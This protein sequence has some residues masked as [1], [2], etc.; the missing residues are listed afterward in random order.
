MPLLKGEVQA[1][2]S[3]QPWAHRGGRVQ[4]DLELH[5]PAT[6]VEAL[7]CFRYMGVNKS[8]PFI[9]NPLLIR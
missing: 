6:G 3:L 8:H 2:L 5:L 1:E 7:W 9:D 4:K